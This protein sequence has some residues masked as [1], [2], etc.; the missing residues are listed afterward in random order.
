MAKKAAIRGLVKRGDSW[1][2]DFVHAGKRYTASVG[3]WEEAKSALDVKRGSLQSE[4]LAREFG[5]K[6]GRG[7]V[8]T[9]TEFYQSSYKP[10]LENGEAAKLTARNDK[11]VLARFGATFGGRSLDSFSDP[12]FDSYKAARR[13]A[14]VGEGT[15]QYDLRRIR[16][17]F[18]LAV[19]RDVIPA[20]PVR[21][22]LIPRAARR[23][24]RLLEPSEEPIF[25]GAMPT[26]LAHDLFRTAFYCVLRRG[27]ALSLR[28]ENVNWSRGE[29]TFTQ[30]K[31]GNVKAVPLIP[32]ALAILRARKPEQ[33]EPEGFVF[34]AKQGK[35]ISE[36]TWFTWWDKTRGACKRAGLNL[37]KC[38]PHDLRHSV[39]QRLE[40]NGVG[41]AT[42]AKALGHGPRGTTAGYTSHAKPE[43]IR[44]ALS[45]IF[46]H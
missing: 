1:G 36:N 28:W 40:D 25:F 4:R 16:A 7:R 23:V 26:P 46:R 2:Y 9:V 5:L 18:A 14:G 30:H 32:E 24:Y 43:Q 8:P 33:A 12:D 3:T 20:N 15:I 29:L 42:Q 34:T 21:G 19:D 22:K 31:T 39:G 37:D 45:E 10:F 38:R 11:Y 41:Q 35:P 27:E 17:F 44:K 13:K 6:R